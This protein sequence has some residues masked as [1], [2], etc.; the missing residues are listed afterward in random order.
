MKIDINLKNIGD[1]EFIK[2]FKINSDYIEQ[3]K[4]YSQSGKSTSY[5]ISGYRGVGK[6]TL[7]RQVEKTLVNEDKEDLTYLFV[8][9]NINNYESQT[10]FLRN[11][12][13]QIHLS[14]ISHKNYSKFKKNNF[15]ICKELD[16][17]YEKTFY[18]IN[19]SFKENRIKTSDFNFKIKVSLKQI[20]KQ[21]YPVIM[22]FS[23]LHYELNFQKYLNVFPVMNILLFIF[24]IIMLIKNIGVFEY[25]KNTRYEKKDE[26]VRKS[27]YD[28]EIA[29]YKLNSIL[30]RLFEKN[31]RTFLIFDEID[32]IEDENTMNSLLGDIKPLILSEE[33]NT[34]LISG[35]K[36][37]YKMMI[38]DIKDDSLM[39]S[40]FPRVIHVKLLEISKLRLIVKKYILNP[41]EG[42]DKLF[43]YYIDSLILNSK[44]ILR[45]LN[46]SI[47]KELQWSEK[48]EPYINI[49]DDQF[50][51]YETDHKILNIIEK[52][53]HTT[54]SSFKL[55]YGLSDFLIYQLFIWT[56]RIKLKG[57]QVF[58]ASEIIGVEDLEEYPSWIVSRRKMI[59]DILLENMKD[60][61]LIVEDVTNESS[62]DTNFRWNKHVNLNVNSS[63]SNIE[64]DFF[65]SFRVL[66]R[67]M[68]VINSLVNDVIEKK[69]MSSILR[70]LLDASVIENSDF[71]DLKKIS[72]YRNKVVHGENLNTIETNQLETMIEQ[73]RRIEVK[74]NEKYIFYTLKQ[75][76]SSYEYFVKPSKVNEPFDIVVSSKNS[77]G[78]KIYFEIKQFSS[79]YNQILRN[80]LSKLK[81][82]IGQSSKQEKYVI[83]LFTSNTSNTSSFLQYKNDFYKRNQNL[84]KILFQFEIKTFDIELTYRFYDEILELN[85]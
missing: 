1:F 73:L 51:S 4:R 42:N 55:E 47:I 22:I 35:Q 7:V 17:L 63:I 12:I 70:D 61:N 14:L 76:F 53:I 58:N 6:T 24:G 8:Y 30:K 57:D 83:I 68:R 36:L 2:K 23:S 59:L 38:S 15:E 52:I 50:D 26:F 79:G 44:M 32:K 19:N 74:L 62:I 46:N 84:K 67:K 5:L 18:E 34:I 28:D 82:L 81:N 40:L 39:T 41:S 37:F 33:C 20:F 10:V 66:E 71:N 13:R 56:R 49:S 69:A 80:Y 48:K 60:A 85:N 27:L 65:E 78:N 16:E 21:L 3:I 9:L 64:L 75:Y 45:V 54:I 77:S 25:L 29:G 31:I 11:L 43:E 72:Y